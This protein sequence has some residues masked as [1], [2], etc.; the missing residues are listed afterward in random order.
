MSE[1]LVEAVARAIGAA[2]LDMR[3][4][5]QVVTSVD[6]ILARAALAAIESTGTHVVAPVR[7]TQEMEVSGRHAYKQDIYRA[8]LAARPKVTP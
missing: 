8:M 2:R 1:E 3:G 6:R 7:P 5:G 4:E